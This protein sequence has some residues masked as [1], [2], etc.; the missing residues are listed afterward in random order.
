MDRLLL[1]DKLDDDLKKYKISD[2]IK[3]GGRK[4]YLIQMKNS[5]LISIGNN[6]KA[7][8][9]SLINKRKNITIIVET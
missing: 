5:A 4:I 3:K 8:L 7:G 2:V 9:V 6:K 1:V